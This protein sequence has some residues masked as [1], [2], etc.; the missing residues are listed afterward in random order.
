MPPRQNQN[1]TIIDSMFESHDGRL[2]R[3]EHGFNQLS[4]QVLPA[5]ARIEAVA[6]AGLNDIS[7]RLD[8]GDRRF[9]E[10]EKTLEAIEKAASEDTSRDVARDIKL[11]ELEK[12]EAERQAAKKSLKK[13]V[14]GVAGTV[15]MAVIMGWLGLD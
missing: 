15:A 8:R 4:A 7:E 3:L 5:L 14:L 13:W 1:D 9:D 2:L 11:G 10:I 6:T 12:V